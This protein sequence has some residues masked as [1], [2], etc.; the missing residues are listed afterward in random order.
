MHRKSNR[1]KEDEYIEG[2]KKVTSTKVLGFQINK[3]TNCQD[4]LEK[5]KGKIKKTHRMIFMGRKN[6]LG[7]W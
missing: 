1:Y 3:D 2:L 5:I 7:R 4:H 6:E